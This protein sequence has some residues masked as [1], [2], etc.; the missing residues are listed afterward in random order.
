L[1]HRCHD[2]QFLFRFAKDRNGYRRR[3]REAASGLEVSILTYNITSNHVHVVAYAEGPEAIATLM[4]QAAG[5]LARDYNRRKSRSG[6][7]WEEG[8]YH[9]TVVDSGEYLWECI[10]HVELNMARCGVVDH[11]RQW[12]WSGYGELMGWRKRNRLLDVEKLLWL[13]RCGSVTELREHLNEAL[14]RA[15]L[16]DELERQAKNFY[17]R[18]TVA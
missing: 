6:A 12:N 17:L 10:I 15:I 5:E 13:L 1:T 8:R 9:A 3:L 2:R 14:E 16:N 7:F 11:P 18:S 4:Q